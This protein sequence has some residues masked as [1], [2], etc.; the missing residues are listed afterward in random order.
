M[1]RLNRENHNARRIGWLRASVQ[2]DEQRREFIA[3][4]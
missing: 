1:T 4:R 3:T 2:R